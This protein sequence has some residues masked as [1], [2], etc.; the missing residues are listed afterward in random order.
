MALCPHCKNNI[1]LDNIKTETKGLGIL[2][3]E[4]LY[5]CPHCKVALGISRGKWTS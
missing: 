3:Q 5:S 2:K 4:I 1:T